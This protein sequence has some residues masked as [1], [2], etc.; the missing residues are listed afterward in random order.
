MLN[1]EVLVL[2]LVVVLDVVL[3]LVVVLRLSEWNRALAL[4]V[5]SERR[6]EACVT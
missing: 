3:V 1:I 4:L 5:R 6:S 2:V